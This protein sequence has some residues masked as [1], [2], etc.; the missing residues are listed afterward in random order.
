MIATLGVSNTDSLW[1]MVDLKGYQ[2]KLVHASSDVKQKNNGI[3]HLKSAH[4]VEPFCTIN[5]GRTVQSLR[6]K[7]NYKLKT[8]I[9]QHVL[10]QTCTFENQKY[11]TVKYL[12]NDPSMALIQRPSMHHFSLKCRKPGSCIDPAHAQW[13]YVLMR[14]ASDM[15]QH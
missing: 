10:I 12:S 5:C 15:V 3:V 4:L 1:F 2:N 11:I 7:K 8:C 9:V 13:S 14:Y 6:I